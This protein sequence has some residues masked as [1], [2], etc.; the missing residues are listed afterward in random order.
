VVGGVS[1]V[2]AEEPIVPS[3]NE[4]QLMFNDD[5]AY[6]H[7]PKLTWRSTR[8][9]FIMFTMAAVMCAVSWSCGAHAARDF[10]NH[11]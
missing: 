8:M 6:E 4:S 2:S 7:G 5:M 10:E 9:R 1:E 11:C 3:A